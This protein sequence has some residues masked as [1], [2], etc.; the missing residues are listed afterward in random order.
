MAREDHRTPRSPLV[1][2]RASSLL[3]GLG[4]VVPAQTDIEYHEKR[5]QE[6]RH[7]ADLPRQ[8][9]RETEM[10]NQHLA[11]RTLSR[12]DFPKP[13]LQA[14][15]DAAIAALRAS[16]YQREVK[17]ILHELVEARY[18]A[19]KFKDP[20]WVAGNR[21]IY[22]DGE[23]FK[24][25]LLAL[26]ERWRE[27][28]LIYEDGLTRRVDSLSQLAQSMQQEVSVA[29]REV[30]EAENRI[31]EMNEM[32]R[33]EAERALEEGSREEENAARHAYQ[34]SLARVDRLSTLLQR[35]VDATRTCTEDV[36]CAIAAA[37]IPR[38]RIIPFALDVQSEPS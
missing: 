19:T 20:R 10:G 1:D 15:I 38:N 30:A 16:D 6:Y 14:I 32:A 29:E 11:D 7:M 33:R 3:D 13:L 9:L 22:L 35:A 23:T 34:E 4:V 17:E 24:E 31:A 12:L 36:S 25:T 37:V 8:F 27:L 26:P 21:R 18:E 28:V 2:F 5:A